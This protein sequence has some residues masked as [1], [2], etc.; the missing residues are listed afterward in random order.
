MTALMTSLAAPLQASHLTTHY[1]PPTVGSGYNVV[2]MWDTMAFLS[3][4]F[5]TSNTQFNSKYVYD[6]LPSPVVNSHHPSA[7]ET[8]PCHK[9]TTRCLVPDSLYLDQY[10]GLSWEIHAHTHTH[11]HIRGRSTHTHTH[12]DGRLGA[13]QASSNVMIYRFSGAA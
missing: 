5:P 6:L 1:V 8:S 2:R 10:P 9:E 4:A 11:T 13:K 7:D 3:A 12:Q